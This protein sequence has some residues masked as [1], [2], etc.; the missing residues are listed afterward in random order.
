MCEQC[1]EL[2]EQLHR[3]SDAHTRT[4]AK[5]IVAEGE[6]Q[7]MKQQLR[8]Q[9]VIEVC[10]RMGDHRYVPNIVDGQFLGMEPAPTYH[11][12]VAGQPGLWAAGYSS[13][14]AIGNLIRTHPE[15]FGITLQYLGRQPR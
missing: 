10:E 4:M 9:V 12:C 7:S 5:L 11:A 14:D 15:A 1:I 8:Q 13:D 6:L 2:N 3:E